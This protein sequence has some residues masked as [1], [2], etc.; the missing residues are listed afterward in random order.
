MH[1]SPRLHSGLTL[2]E[3]LTAIGVVGVLAAIAL[4]AWSAARAAVHSSSARTA[5]TSTLLDSERHALVSRT[6]A[7]MC[8]STSGTECTGGTDWSQ[9]W[10]A[11]SDLDSNRQRGAAEPLIDQ[12]PPLEGGVRLRSTQGR[13]RLVFQPGG[14]NAGSNVTMTLCD[15]RGVRHAV[16]LVLAN[17]G[18]TRVGTP[19]A[20]AAAAC[21]YG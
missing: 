9:G 7:V 6:E 14:S 20:A 18:R 8:P 1:G 15:A 5:I 10:I 11:F 12:A 17:S 13:T 21:V 3:L 2:L 4:P 16:T 19:T